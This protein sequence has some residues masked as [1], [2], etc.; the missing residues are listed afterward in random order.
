LH[1]VIHSNDILRQNSD[2]ADLNFEVDPNRHERASPDRFELLPAARV[3]GLCSM[4]RQDGD[5]DYL[6]GMPTQ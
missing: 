5:H 4:A 1:L 3:R 6:E 2:R